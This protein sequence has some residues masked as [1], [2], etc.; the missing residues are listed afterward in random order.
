MT[1]VFPKR[2]VNIEIWHDFESLVELKEMR[3]E[4]LKIIDYCRTLQSW[5]SSFP[6]AVQVLVSKY[7]SVTATEAAA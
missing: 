7:E 6:D 3:T 2:S 1:K 4:E 5:E